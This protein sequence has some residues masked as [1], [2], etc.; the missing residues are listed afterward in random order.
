MQSEEDKVTRLAVKNGQGN[1]MRR[2]ES[3]LLPRERSFQL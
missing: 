3:Y 2:N 1:Q